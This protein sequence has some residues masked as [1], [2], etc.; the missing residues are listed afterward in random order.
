MYASHKIGVNLIRSYFP[1]KTQFERLHILQFGVTKK[2]REPMR[3]SDSSR[4]C[5]NIIT[6]GLS[7]KPSRV[8]IHTH[9]DPTQELCLLSFVTE[10]HHNINP[11]LIWLK[12]VHSPK[13]QRQKTIQFLIQSLICTFSSDSTSTHILSVALQSTSLWNYFLILLT[14]E[15]VLADC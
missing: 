6:S 9:K 7:Y 8:H 2:R 15:L 10:S 1:Y 12:R 13:Q 5:P 4:H 3:Q 11:I 14:K